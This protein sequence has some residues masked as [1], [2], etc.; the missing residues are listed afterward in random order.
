VS[1]TPGKSLN[2]ILAASL[3]AALLAGCAKGGEDEDLRKARE[4]E[5]SN[6]TEGKT[7]PPRPAPIPQNIV[8]Y[9]PDSVKAKF[10]T[11]T[12]AV[13]D[14]QTKEIRRFTVKI[15]G[16]AAVPGTA[17]TVK[18]YSYLPHWVL[19]NNTTTTKSDRPDDPAVRA[20]ITEGGRKVFDGFIFQRHKT[21]SFMT[22]KHV[23]GLLDAG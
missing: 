18:V 15:G 3:L 8:I 12:M 2:I 20:E 1:L 11:V 14:R 4:W 10:S 21:P 7:P 6:F 13:G 23:I 9:V 5:L 16:S 17:Y 19:R 22:E